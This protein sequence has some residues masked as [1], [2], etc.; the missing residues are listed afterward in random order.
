[1]SQIAAL[2]ALEA[3]REWVYDKVQTLAT[4]RKLILDALSPLE[5]TMSGSGSNVCNGKTTSRCRCISWKKIYGIA[6]IPS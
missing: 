2:G 1:M 3:G 6:I 4:G 5:E